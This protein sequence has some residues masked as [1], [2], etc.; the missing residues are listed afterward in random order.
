VSDRGDMLS[1]IRADLFL[2][3]FVK[4][5]FLIVGIIALCAAIGLGLLAHKSGTGPVPGMRTVPMNT[6]AANF[7]SHKMP[8]AGDSAVQKKTGTISNAHLNGVY[9][10][11]TISALEPKKKIA[12]VQVPKP[13][14]RLSVPLTASTT[15]RLKEE[16]TQDIKEAQAAKRTEVS[17]ENKT[18]AANN[19]P[20]NA[21]NCK[22]YPPVCNW[23]DA[24]A[25]CGG[26]LP[27]AAQLK[28]IYRAECTEGRLAETC[29]KWYWSLDEEGADSAQV[30]AFY[31]GNVSND[32][33]IFAGNA[34]RCER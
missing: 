8:A 32:H 31:T 2:G 34:V 16:L 25:Y 24:M 33:K 9:K 29:D 4:Y 26:L 17:S 1:F 30:M 7:E 21:A 5:R 14:P 28:S 12:I 3:K 18:G 11:E 22:G 27:T 19:R 20:G 15:G 6:S 23:Y 13:E 10:K